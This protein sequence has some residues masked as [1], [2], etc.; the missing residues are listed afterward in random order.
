MKT[1]WGYTKFS[2]KL[3]NYRKMSMINWQKEV[4]W[5]KMQRKSTIF[6]SWTKSDLTQTKSLMKHSKSWTRFKKRCSNSKPSKWKKWTFAKQRPSFFKKNLSCWW[7]KIKISETLNTSP[8]FSTTNS[9]RTRECPFLNAIKNG[10]KISSTQLIIR[11]LK[12]I[13]NMCLANPL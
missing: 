3:K 5:W 12:F 13:I 9:S 7:N 2:K 1:K 8:T 6:R 10:T 4:W 11:T